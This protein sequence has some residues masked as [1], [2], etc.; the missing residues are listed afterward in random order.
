MNSPKPVIQLL[1]VDDSPFVR[2]GVKAII[3]TIGRGSGINV[4]GEAASVD[5]AIRKSVQL[6]P[7]VVLLDIRLP[8]GSGIA[9]C[10]KIARQDPAPK[11]LIFTSHISDPLIYEAITAGAEG[12]LMKEIDPGHLI[13]SIQRVHD[14]ATILSPELAS[15]MINLVRKS[16]EPDERTKFDLLSNQE[17]RVLALVAAGKTNKEVSADLGLS[18]NTVKN[19]LGSVYEKLGVK[20]RSQAASVYVRVRTQT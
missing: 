18:E 15:R 19:Y 7:D 6:K 11:V 5:E 17:R 10:E 2:Q 1:I 4:V 8:D 12:Y 13:D 20:R 3:E 16:A 9:A 14:G